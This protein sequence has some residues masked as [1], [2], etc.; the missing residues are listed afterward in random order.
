MP[1]RR[2]A[3]RE[4]N[5]PAIASPSAHAADTDAL[6]PAAFALG[7]RV[8]VCVPVRD[9]SAYLVA[10]LDA[11]ARQTVPAQAFVLCLL[12]DGCNDDGEAL[13][14]AR[15]PALAYDIVTRRI[16]RAPQ[17]N[18]G[19]ARRAAMALGRSALASARSVRER[20]M[21]L[22]ST[23]AD[24]IPAPDW[25]E[26]NARTLAAVDVVAGYIERPD[27]P[28]EDV[29]RRIERYWERLRC[30]QRTVDPLGHDP[31]PSHPSQ[32]GASLGF[33]ADVYAALG[34][35]EA[36]ASHEDVQI[37]T[38]ARRAGYRVCHD[39]GVR[40]ATSSRTDGRASDGLASTLRARQN[41][42]AP[43]LVQDPDAALQR[44]RLSA[45]TRAGFAQL[46]DDEA[47]ARALATATG[48]GLET[49]REIA[50][51]CGNAEAFTMQL[52]P[53]PVKTEELA[54]EQAEQRLAF[55]ENAYGCPCP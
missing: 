46:F 12:F 17:A 16:E 29:H 15:A 25:V 2:H 1:S 9:E 11:F 10:L 38:A 3:M 31:A 30:L 41:D 18:A 47:T 21:L 44:Y 45:Q 53:E 42:S 39:R 14:A 26:A 37:V 35:F 40:V 23:D 22:L 51:A 7:R 19:R 33:R 8:A 24:S 5:P 49:L 27:A 4:P 52:V 55:L 28:A 50:T 48:H 13:V 54:L 32:G 6:L 43:P 20:D 34:G 36:L